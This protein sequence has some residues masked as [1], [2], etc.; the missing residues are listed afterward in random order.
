MTCTPGR[1]GHSWPHVT[2]QAGS[3][4]ALAWLAAAME[5][6][7]LGDLFAGIIGFGQFTASAIPLR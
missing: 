2:S 1:S 3:R 5:Q 4:R 7:F 6:V